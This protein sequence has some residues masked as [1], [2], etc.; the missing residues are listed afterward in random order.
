LGIAGLTAWRFRLPQVSAFMAAAG[1]RRLLNPYPSPDFKA[2]LAE[3][4]VLRPVRTYTPSHSRGMITYHPWYHHFQPSMANRCLAEAAELGVG[5]IRID[6]RWRDLLP[7]GRNVDEAAWSWYQ[8]YLR[9][10]RDWYGLEPLIVLSNAPDV[11]LGLP[12][13]SRL[14]AWIQYVNEVAHRVGTLCNVYQLLNEPNNPVYRIFPMKTTAAAVQSGAD[15]IRRQ[16]PDAKIA[17]NL[18]AGLWGWE[19]DLEK[20][21]QDSGSAVDIVGLDY[22]PGTWTVSPRSD[23]ATWD[24]FVDLIV[25]SRERSTS[26]LYGKPLAIIETG[27]ATNSGFGRDEE[28]QRR[29]FQTLHAAMERLDARTGRDGLLMIGIHELSDGDTNALF[30]PEA[31]FGLLTSGT[32]RR[33]AGF[34]AARQIFSAFQ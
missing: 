10:A 5:H 3:W 2:L 15:A 11:V 26:S 31:R 12:V 8:S 6:I 18:L 13:D 16:S 7:D 34:D 33:K 19:T 22:Y 27:Y 21:I 20:I 4:L 32:L 24:H 25:G 9:A 29:Y 17:I 23:S 1:I 14:V 28:H 30:D